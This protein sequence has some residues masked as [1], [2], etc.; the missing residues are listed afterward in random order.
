[1]PDGNIKDA[2]ESKIAILNNFCG[3]PNFSAHL[4]LLGSFLGPKEILINNTKR[5]SKIIKPFRVTFKEIKFSDEFFYSVFISIYP[6]KE[7][8]KARK[9]SCELF[10]ITDT[11]YLPHVSLVYG[12]YTI[13]KKIKM[14]QLA[15]QIPNGFH[16]EKIFLAFNDEI[17]LRWEIIKEFKLKK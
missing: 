1:M 17:N 14:I 6:S 15:K 4:T 9:I 11:N 10:N 2:I 7:L 5:L 8:L 13:N 3:G 16:A 12:N